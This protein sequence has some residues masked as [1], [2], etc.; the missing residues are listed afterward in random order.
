LNFLAADNANGVKGC[1]C[2]WTGE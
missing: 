1:R 2:G